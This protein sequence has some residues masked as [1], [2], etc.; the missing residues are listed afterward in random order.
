MAEYTPLKT[1][2]EYYAPR[3]SGDAPFNTYF[4]D[5]TATGL[6][7]TIA[8]TGA[9]G[10]T[11]PTGNY[12]HTGITGERGATGTTGLLGATGPTGSTGITGPT[13]YTGYTGSQGVTGPEGL[14]GS[15]GLNAIGVT[16][17]TGPVGFT[18]YTGFTGETGY[19]G[20]TGPVGITGSVGVT[21][22]ALTGLQGHTGYTGT[23]GFTG[24]TGTTGPTG[25]QGVT[26]VTGVTGITGAFGATGHTG[27]TGAPNLSVYVSYTGLE[28]SLAAYA[29]LDR[30]FSII[31]VNLIVQSPGLTPIPDVEFIIRPSQYDTTSITSAIYGTYELVRKGGTVTYVDQSGSSLPSYLDI[32]TGV[33]YS[34]D[35]GNFLLGNQ[36]T[37]FMILAPN[38]SNVST[39]VLV[40]NRR[41]ITSGS[42]PEFNHTLEGV[43]AYSTS[44]N[45]P[46]I[47][48]SFG[49]YQDPA[50][51]CFGYNSNTRVTYC[52][53]NNMLSQY[54]NGSLDL[55]GIFA[56][57]NITTTYRNSGYPETPPISSVTS[58]TNIVNLFANQTAAGAYSANGFIGK[59]YYFN[60]YNSCLSLNDALN[61]FNVL[62]QQYITAPIGPSFNYSII[63]ADM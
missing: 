16:G 25:L 28:N 24:W 22:L 52:I 50:I 51:Y 21:G 45:T 9:T 47:Y 57:S 38:V 20:P 63:E 59:F 36:Y 34:N 39:N 40:T 8:G 42:Y 48:S 31:G 27:V 6:A 35:A 37:I 26:G 58:S 7:S 11:G 30:I 61:V 10:P 60:K 23:R 55:Y 1:S 29:T 17:S 18:G 49:T 13:G 62:K 14:Q 5:I 53:N 15:P 43:N 46:H 41:N 33:S 54:Q 19:T 56:G 4:F 44:T 3:Y 32:P 12:G 2:A